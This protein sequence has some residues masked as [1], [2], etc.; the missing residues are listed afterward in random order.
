MCV[1][2][3]VCVCVVWVHQKC[4]HVVCHQCLCVVSVSVIRNV[5]YTLY[6]CVLSDNKPQ[7]PIMYKV[8]L[9]PKAGYGGASL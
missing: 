1:C 2:V 3:C 8:A 9:S 6:V 4:F 7:E 5:L